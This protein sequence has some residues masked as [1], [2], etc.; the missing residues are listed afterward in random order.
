MEPDSLSQGREFVRQARATGSPDMEIA[1]ALMEQGWSAAALRALSYTLAVPLVVP[2][3]ALYSAAGAAPPQPPPVP[4]PPDGSAPPG[5]PPSVAQAPPLPPPPAPPRPR[6]DLEIAIGATWLTRIGMVAVLLAVGFLLKHAFSEGWITERILV[7]VGIVAGVA[8]LAGGEY[9]HQ[10]GYVS[11]SQALT[12]GGAAVL[13]LTLWAGQHLYGLLGSATT[14]PMMAVVTVVAAAQAIR[15]ESETVATFA[16]VTGYA[17][18]LLIGGG[19]GGAA[20][21]GGPGPLFAYLSLLSVAVVVVTQRYLWPTFTGLALL[22]AYTSGVYISRVSG[23]AL[24]WTLTYL[25][26][27]TA[28]M[29]WVSV[30][31]QGRRGESFGAVGAAA[32][33]FVTGVV[34]MSETSGSPFIPYLYLLALSGSA[35]W[36]GHTQDWRGMRWVGAL[37]SFVGFLLLLPVIRR[38][39]IAGMGD[40]ML[41]Y[42]AM[43]VAGTLAVSGGREAD[44]EPLA[45]AAVGTA[46]AAV[47]TLVR[48]APVGAASGGACFAFLTLLAGGVVFIALHFPWKHFSAL[49]LAA[50]FLA[51]GLLSVDVVGGRIV[52]FPL[53]YLALIGPAALLTSVH[54]DSRALGTISVL[55]IYAGLM[56]S[57]MI[58]SA[59]PE[60]AVPGC[61]VLAAVG[62]LSAIERRAWY[63]LEWA[64]LAGTWAAY[65][66]WRTT[67]GRWDADPE[68]L[69]FT[70]LYFIVFIAA[71][72]LR[73]G[74]LST[75][76]GVADAVLACANAGAFFWMGCHDVRQVEAA[77]PLAVALAVLYAVVGV[78]AVRRRPEQTG[79]GP[80]HIGLAIVFITAAIALLAHGYQMTVLWAVEVVVL[81]G[82]GCQFR[83]RALRDAALVVLILPLVRAIVI[84]S[85]IA[86][87]GYQWLLNSR[88]ESMLAVVAAMYVCGYLYARMGDDVDEREAQS[89]VGLVALATVLLWWVVSGE[90]W[91]FVGWQLGLGRSAQHFAL[92]GVWVVFSVALMAAGIVYHSAGFRW[93]S[94]GLLAV[95]TLK[96]LA[97]D[98]PLFGATYVPLLNAHA[99]PLLA[100]ALI[101]FAAAAW[102]ARSPEADEAERQAGTTLLVVGTGLLLWVYSTEAW[103]AIGWCSPYG[104]ATQQAALSGGWLVFGAVMLWMGM[105]RSSLAMRATGLTVL[106]IVAGKVL[107]IDPALTATTYVPLA[108]YHAL[109]LLVIGGI[110]FAASGWYGQTTG[111]VDDEEAAVA[112]AIPYAG[113]LLLLWVLST[114]AWY[115]ADWGLHAG[116]DA[117]QYALSMVWAVY[118]AILVTIGLVRSNPPLRWM[119]IILLG[120]TVLKVFFLDLRELEMF[121]R[122][123]VLLG[124][125]IVLIAVGFAYQRLVRQQ[126]E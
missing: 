119:A 59:A 96:I 38:A 65:L 8:I 31:R 73:Q 19:A 120:M 123:L 45:L 115:F 53:I 114:E 47:F 9:A 69:G 13:Y 54:R 27:V 99:T 57:T 61:L 10:Q 14:F 84:D 85:Q 60:L 90:T 126:D 49:G 108:N 72:W 78:T 124:L 94:L 2:W 105:R 12:G 51:T 83:S 70:A 24:G 122:I 37:G 111:C 112:N 43:C 121:Y 100:I 103:L 82:L 101:A 44:A 3:A 81:M 36:L 107:A 33:Y 62:C 113:G 98:P 86:Q 71:A 110:L 117:Q 40:W 106:A 93:A 11:Q 6:R 1:R 20:D 76:A 97:G 55:G 116:R 92:S 58:G 48:L 102:Y 28:G 91:S 26:L 80:V 34:L 66:L 46:Y 15:H 22:G 52:D 23:G 125:G 21:S 25:M 17:V 41:L 95:T 56:L 39:G 42:A 77:G 74:V 29:L 64:A 35:L 32:G 118:G 87:Q 18:P 104:L 109:P 75:S 7:A 89:S 30:S 16:W 4:P 88:A 67:G 68:N 79:L 5:V 63:G 50:A